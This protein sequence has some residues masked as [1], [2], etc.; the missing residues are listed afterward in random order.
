[1]EDMIEMVNYGNESFLVL[2]KAFQ[3]ITLYNNLS[4]YDILI[5]K[6]NFTFYNYYQ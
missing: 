2:L 4:L 1:M 5:N 6:L 3:Y